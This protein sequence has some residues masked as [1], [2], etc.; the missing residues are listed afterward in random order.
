[1]VLVADAAAALSLRGAPRAPLT[2]AAA[3][4]PLTAALVL[5]RSP[6]FG[7][8][9]GLFTLGY[10]ALGA[11]GALALTRDDRTRTAAAL[12]CVWA[13]TEALFG[14][15]VGFGLNMAAGSLVSDE[16]D[17]TEAEWGWL[18]GLV[19]LN[20][21]LGFVSALLSALTA[22]DLL[23]PRSSFRSF[24]VSESPESS[25]GLELLSAGGGDLSTQLFGGG[26]EKE[27]PPLRSPG[28][29]AAVAWAALLL[30][31]TLGFAATQVW[32][33]GLVVREGEPWG[34]GVYAACKGSTCT[35]RATTCAKETGTCSCTGFAQ[36][37]R[38]SEWTEPQAVTGSISCTQEAF[39]SDP[40]PDTG[41]Y[42]ECQADPLRPISIVGRSVSPER[43]E[44]TKNI[45]YGANINRRPTFGDGGV[46][47]ISEVHE[48]LLLDLYRPQR[49]VDES[50]KSPATRPA[51]VIVHGGSF[52]GGS[53]NDTLCMDEAR[54]FAQHSYVA[55]SI[56]YRLSA[57]SF[58]PELAAVRDAVEDTKAAV[59]WLKEHSA[60]YG[61]DVDR[62]AVW[63]GSAGAMT[64]G[65]IGWIADEGSSSTNTELS[66][67]V[68]AAV[69]ISGCLW[70][71]FLNSAD[72]P[73]AVTA[74]TAVPFFDV[75]GDEDGR[76]YPFLAAFTS[77]YLGHLGV[78][79]AKN[80][81][82]SA[83]LDSRLFGCMGHFVA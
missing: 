27:M 83:S 17:V 49:W 28:T 42:C 70:P 52:V 43:I 79:P 56:D 54:Y 47:S 65:S 15:I 10:C 74:Q 31:G 33:P 59:R 57:T 34:Y 69:G 1:M 6:M 23:R 72:A 64:A 51:I 2:A 50:P 14:M 36:Y 68:A 48:V 18:A 11:G 58:L 46:A 30:C 13:A 73:S 78:A 40:L 55:V 19:Y 66:S 75:H 62:I 24:G 35:S 4:V 60:E 37:G 32:P 16:M 39:G 63:G 45:Q 12:Y 20:Y 81:L 80:R 26:R 22:R 76:V 3:A 53:K 5:S 71:F 38:G 8:Q 7:S 67:K 9:L 82:A 77:R 44:V 29:I 21:M 41:K 25:L 61:I